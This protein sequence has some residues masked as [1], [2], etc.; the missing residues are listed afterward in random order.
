MSWAVNAV[1]EV[2]AGAAVTQGLVMDAVVLAVIGL[3]LLTAAPLT[4]PRRTR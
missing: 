4:M 3:V 2:Q 1:G